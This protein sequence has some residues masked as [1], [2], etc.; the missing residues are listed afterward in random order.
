MG[1]NSSYIRKVTGLL[2]K[3][4]IIESRQGASGYQLMVKPEELTLYEVYQAVS[5]TEQ[6]HVF[7]L[8]QNPNDQCIVGKHIRPVLTD[9]FRA[10]EEKAEQELR[11]TTLKCCMDRM[12]GEIERSGD[13]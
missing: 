8:H 7:D 4:G 3:K 12:R 6:V 13:Q 2:K 9:V 10:V 11:G 1:T 5:E